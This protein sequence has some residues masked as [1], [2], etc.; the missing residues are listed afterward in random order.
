VAPDILLRYTAE[1]FSVPKLFS[2]KETVTDQEI[3]FLSVRS[4]EAL[5]SPDHPEGKRL[6]FFLQGLAVGGVTLLTIMTASIAITS[7]GAWRY[8]RK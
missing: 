4:H 6:D 7:W 5:V 8:F 2:V 3:D 1:M